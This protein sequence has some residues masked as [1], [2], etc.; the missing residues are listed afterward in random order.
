MKRRVVLLVIM[1]LFTNTIWAD[2]KDLLKAGNYE[3]ALREV[4]S[5]ALRGNPEAQSILGT[6]YANGQG[7][8]VNLAKAF[9]WTRKAAEKGFANAQYNLGI[10]YD[11][12]V[13]VSQNYKEAAVW[14]GK[15]ARKNVT[16]AQYNLGSM[17]YDGQGVNKDY[18]QA[19][20][21]ISLSA[22]AGDQMAKKKKDILTEKMTPEQIKKANALI[23]E[24]K[25][26]G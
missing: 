20:F 7:V 26:H 6:M 19:Y 17:Y 18:V 11:N 8:P 1:L 2:Y 15:A 24:W 22:D 23:A 13:G 9:A 16:E 3:A 10:M 25:S 12:G 4:K 21:W 5:L 14:Y